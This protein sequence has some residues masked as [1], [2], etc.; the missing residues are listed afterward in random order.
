M[1]PAGSSDDRPRR[2]FHEPIVGSD[3]PAREIGSASFA[4]LLR[5]LAQGVADA[6][7]A[8]DISSA[9]MPEEMSRTRVPVVTEIREVIDEDGQRIVRDAGP[10][11]EMSLLDLG[12]IPTFYQ[13][14]ES[15][16]E[17]AMDVSIVE[18]EEETQDGGARIGLRAST[19]ALRAERKLRREIGAHSKM[20][21]TLVPV[22]MPPGI[23]PARTRVDREG[24]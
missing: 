23:D 1:A 15:K 24:R 6:Q 11:E 2:G 10:V 4:D 19:A 21:A 12:L 20:T 8:L 16:V 17:V 18:S 3:V 7:A 22:P 14:S 5:M 13:F 9:E